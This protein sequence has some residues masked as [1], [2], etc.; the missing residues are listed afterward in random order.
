MP[1]GDTIYRTAAVLRPAIEGRTIGLARL[2]DRQFEPE[3]LAGATIAGV[4]AHGKHL[5]MHLAAGGAIHS[6]LGMTGSWH[7]YQPGEAWR[8]PAHYASLQLEF[9][10]GELVAICF[11]PKLLEL[12]TPDQLRR[13]PHLA[14]L[15]PDLLA[16]E[17]DAAAAVLRFRARNALPLGE[18]V[19]NQTIV[20]GIG[21]V[22]KSD[23]LFLMGFD[24]LA[25]VERFSDTELATMLEK[26]RWLM[27][28]NLAGAPR[29]T[30]FR[31]DGRRLW[32]YGRSGEPCY[33]CGATIALVRQGD[34]GRTTCWCPQCQP[35]R[36]LSTG[37]RPGVAL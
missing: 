15:G 37:L 29:Q 35:A 10:H 27:R 21:N 34:A 36:R 9:A 4:E 6:H 12:L 18:A 13:H 11:S 22:Y 3:R 25:P 16:A 30:R 1:E 33:K 32:V 14:R 31:G 28:R 23:L 7:L 2:R 19:M 24:P 5:L 26:A 20:C 17:F 8:K